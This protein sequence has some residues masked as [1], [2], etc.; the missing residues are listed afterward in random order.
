MLR[1]IYISC[2]LVALCSLEGV[3]QRSGVSKVPLS[4]K[5]YADQIPAGEM[6]HLYL[7]GDRGQL[8]SL[9][10]ELGGHF[11]R[12]NGTHASVSL[13][14]ESILLLNDRDEVISVHLELGQGRALL[15]ESRASTRIDRV[16]NG[17]AGLISELK[18]SGVLVG[19]IDAGLDLEHPDFLD[20]N[21]NTRVIELWDQTM[22]Y[23]AQRT[24]Q[25]GY[26]QV[27]D[28]ADINQNNCPHVD[29]A[30]FY[31]HGTNT[32]G[33]AVG[34]GNSFEQYTGCAPE[35]EIVVVSSNFN[36]FSWT[37][38]VADAVDFILSIADSLDR[39]CVINASIGAYNG[40]HDGLDLPSSEI[41]DLISQN[42]SRAMVC[43]AGNSG[44]EN[45]Y[46]LGYEAGSDTNFTWFETSAS[47]SIGNGIIFYELYGDV[48]D[49][50]SIIFAIGADKVTPNVLYRGTTSFDSIQNRLYVNETD[51]LFSLAGN[52]L[53]KVQTW[54]D[55]ANGRGM[56][57]IY[58]SHID[59][60]QYKYRL[61][62]TGSGRLDV[63]ST[64]SGIM[65]LYDMVSEGLPSSSEFPAIANYKLP[66]S[67]QQIVSNWACSDKVITVGN[68]T[69][70]NEY[71]DVDEL[72]VEF[73]TLTP[74]AIAASSSAGPNRLGDRKPEVAAPGELTI[75]AGAGFQIEAQL[76]NVNQRNR[77][78]VG[79]LHN[80][81]GGTSSASP[82]VAGMAA[83][84]FELCPDANWLDFKTALTS[85]AVEDGLTGSVPNDR[86]GFGKADAMNA[87][88]FH[89]PK[90]TIGTLSNEFCEGDELLLS[91]DALGTSVLWNTGQAS[92][93]IQVSSSG[94]H[95]A[96]VTNDLGCSDYTDTL[97]VFERPIPIKPIIEPSAALP[98]CLSDEL[99]ITIEDN[100]GSYEWNNAAHTFSTT[101]DTAGVYWCL[102]TNEYG[103]SISSDSL[104]ITFHSEQENPDL[105]LQS[106]DQL[107]L[108][109]DSVGIESY[110]WYRNNARIEN[111]IDSVFEVASAGFYVG[112]IIDSN[113][114][115]WFSK[116]MDIGSLSTETVGLE[117][118]KLFPNPAEN[119]I[120]LQSSLGINSWVITDI[121]GAIVGKG[122]SADYS[123]I[124]DLSDLS[125]GPYLLE[126]DTEG[127]KV[128]KQF[129][130]L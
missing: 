85:G 15:N 74:G 96:L 23:S 70:R 43:A 25:Y 78:G 92:S 1:L 18:G 97:S 79:G 105:H 82:V 8:E 54:A 77:V 16:H 87:L 102:V 125:S 67:K 108:F 95:H 120:R 22:G 28:S 57:Q 47:A 29:Q 99:E 103:C 6:L 110:R 114:C 123:V 4:F 121:S 61:S 107:Q 11:K 80:R 35:S 68:Y 7:K 89:S 109:A 104:E 27:Y 53:A 58:I 60:I 17:T 115:E 56:L 34:N 13:P 117:Y 93:S 32:T 81:A 26:G 116:G 55:T 39:P 31:G 91:V 3:A 65:N 21:G 30:L 33:I 94:L 128:V 90:K 37:A 48:N 112:S 101:I 86:W 119:S 84:F 62:I 66:D 130:K 63:W 5:H 14:K 100:Y 71:I 52:Y 111:A 76:A 41:A 12:Y 19:V 113:G 72:E 126:V 75:T 106:G 49:F 118:V 10:T 38:T 124:V 83:L 50:E 36:S 64:S 127:S 44:E 98:A 88:H 20:A 46:H 24:P 122:T 51:S 69:N 42:S 2:L 40:S 9:T 45:A 59:S 129:M 73:S